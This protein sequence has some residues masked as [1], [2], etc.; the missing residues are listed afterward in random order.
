MI[1]LRVH[2]LPAPQGSKRHVGR[3]I[4]VESSKHVG[5][6]REAVVSEALRSGV[7]DLRTDDP[8]AVRITFWLPRPASHKTP[9]GLRRISAPPYPHRKP[10]I[11]KLLRST[12]DGLV[13]AA[14]IADD[15]RV[16]SVESRKRYA[17]FCAVGARI[18]ITTITD[19]D[20]DEQ[21]IP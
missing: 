20:T 9:K 6:W 3:G 14:V 18:D 17:D 4:L 1:T 8:V 5:P 2:G 19:T 10:D 12:L 16:I 15:A 11:D 7:A 13:Q 21:D